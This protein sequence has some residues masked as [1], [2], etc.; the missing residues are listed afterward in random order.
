MPLSS[1]TSLNSVTVRLPKPACSTRVYPIAASV[2][3]VPGKS[4]ASWSRSVNSWMLIWSRGTLSLSHPLSALRQP[5]WASAGVT[6]AAEPRDGGSDGH[7]AQEVAAAYER[8]PIFRAEV[9]FL[10]GVHTR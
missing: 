3:I 5:S 2:A 7:P 4:M 10:I 6:N 9:V 8:H 1:S